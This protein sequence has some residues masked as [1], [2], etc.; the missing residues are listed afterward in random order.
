MFC[1]DRNL[2]IQKLKDDDFYQCHPT[3]APSTITPS[4]SPTLIN[5]TSAEKQYG[6][7]FHTLKRKKHFYVNKFYH[8]NE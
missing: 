3:Q 5:E 7:K 4:T 6:K 8:Q 2:I 1:S